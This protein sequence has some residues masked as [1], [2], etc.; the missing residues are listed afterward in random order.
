MK[1]PLYL[2]LSLSLASCSWSE[3]SPVVEG[4][5]G[6][7]YKEV[8]KVV[9]Y[10]FRLPSDGSTEPVESGFT[11][12]RGAALDTQALSELSVKSVELTEPQVKRLLNASFSAD[13]IA[14]PAACYD[15]HHI[16]VFYSV[17]GKPLNAIEVCFS[18]TGMST[19]PG[20]DR[21]YWNRCDFSA[22][23]RLAEELGLWMENRTVDEYV[24]QQ[25]EWRAS[26]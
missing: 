13:K 22:L 7:Q 12:L 10:R 17:D 24:K 5:P 20:A 21:A 6:W 1:W 9:G 3:E 18:C 15:P 23:A 14:S 4:N 2:T 25:V 8:A 26:Q 16:F 19:L 11:L